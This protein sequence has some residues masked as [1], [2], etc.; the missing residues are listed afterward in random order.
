MIKTL[1]TE[2]RS[3]LKDIGEGV[4]HHSF[5]SVNT[6]LSYCQLQ[7]FFRYI[8]KLL[9][10]RVGVPLV[11]GSAMNAAFLV[12]DEDLMKGQPPNLERAFEAL[13]AH[14]KM[15]FANRDVPVAATQGETLDSLAKLGK[16]M[17]ERYISQV[18]REEQPIDLERRF[19]VP[20]F[21]KEGNA[22][23]R[24][25]MGEVDR[26]VRLPNGSVVIDDWKTSKSRWPESKIK[27]DDQATCYYIGGAHILGERPA[28][29]RY[30]VLLKTKDAT[31]VTCEAPRT[32]RDERRFIKKVANVDKALKSGSFAPN[33]SSFSCG[34][35]A[36]RNACSKWQDA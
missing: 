6:Y 16:R 31:L 27:K 21:D 19:L 23:P 2:A 17:L 11:F 29:V 28:L 1:A 25:L 10:E 15:A 26:W 18:S 13:H 7:Y 33:D 14:L 5:S 9:Q 4:F 34:T 22:L 20:L 35:C 32:D 30:Q 24:P 12:I 3:I 8:A 36:Y